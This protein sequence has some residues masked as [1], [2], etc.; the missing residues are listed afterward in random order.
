[1]VRRVKFIRV[2]VLTMRVP[3]SLI[4]WVLMFVVGVL[5]LMVWILLL[6]VGG[7]G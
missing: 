4:T 6:V 1:M 7:E 3:I 5:I 2:L